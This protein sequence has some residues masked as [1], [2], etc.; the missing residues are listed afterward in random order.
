MLGYFRCGPAAVAAIKEKAL[1]Y[2]FD[3]KFVFSE[4]SSISDLSAIFSTSQITQMI[5]WS[6]WVAYDITIM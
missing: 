1:S 4:V 5:Y 2:P 3:A 6:S